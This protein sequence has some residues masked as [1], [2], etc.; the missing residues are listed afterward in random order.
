MG[1]MTRGQ[2]RR[3]TTAGKREADRARRV[4]E[5]AEAV[6]EVFAG[7]TEEDPKFWPTVFRIVIAELEAEVYRYARDPDR[8]GYVTQDDHAERKPEYRVALTLQ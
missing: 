1:S 7:A 6:L 8:K 5:Q 3:I 4:R 2:K